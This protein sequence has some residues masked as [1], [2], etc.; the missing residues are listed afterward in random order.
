MKGLK[1]ISAIYQFWFINIDHY[2]DGR[3]NLIIFPELVERSFFDIAV[4]IYIRNFFMTMRKFTLEVYSTPEQN[5]SV[6]KQIYFPFAALLGA[7]LTLAAC[8]EKAQEPERPNILF[9]SVDDLRPELNCYGAPVHSPNIDQLAAEGIMFKHHYIQMAVCIPSRAALLIGVRPERSHQVYGPTIWNQ[10]PGIKSWGNTFREAGYNSIALGKIWHS[11][12]GIFPDT[13]DISWRPSGRYTYAEFDNQEAWVARK[14]NQAVSPITEQ[15]DVHDTAYIDGKV[16]VRAVEELKR[17]SQED[18][19]F[20]LAVGFVKPHLPFCS[21][22]KYWDLYKE[23]EMEL[24][25][26]PDFPVNM[27]DIAFANHPNFFAYTYGD[28]PAFEQG[29]PMPDRTARHLRHAY[30]AATSYIDAQVGIIMEELKRLGLDKNTIV[31]LWGDHGFHLGDTG[32]WSKHYNF[33]WAAHSPLII[34]IPWN[35]Q[36]NIKTDALVESVDIFPTLLELCGIN[37][38]EVCDGK[39]MVPLL[40]NPDIQ[41]KNAIYHVFNRGKVIGHAVRTDRYRFVS[42]REGWGM[43]GEEVAAELYDYST[44][45]IET[46]NLA[47]DPEYAEVRMEMEQLLREGPPGMLNPADN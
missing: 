14:P 33:E 20:M 42:W 4:A 41:W 15:A 30:R 16:A 37:E 21:P 34:K 29:K 45:P 13:F 31:V 47:D 18:K 2:S 9:I 44:V 3:V 43:D 35:K 39:S 8:N 24:A 40:N 6:M 26:N 17:L 25:P 10:V 22:K 32:F 7:S 23:D 38:L 11:F 27:P 46:R 12:D 36:K 1:R 19:P 5:Y 28:Y